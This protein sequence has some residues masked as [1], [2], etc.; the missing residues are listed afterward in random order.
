MNWILVATQFLGYVGAFWLIWKFLDHA[1]HTWK[2][3]VKTGCSECDIR[4]RKLRKANQ[5][6]ED[7]SRRNASL[8]Q[9][10]DNCKGTVKRQTDPDTHKCDYRLI[11]Q[12]NVASEKNLEGI[13]GVGPKKAKLI[14]QRRPFKDMQEVREILPDWLIQEARKWSTFFGKNNRPLV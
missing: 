14:V 9:E 10:L 8:V 2:G 7:L 1:Y 5:L 6:N 11:H 3:D 13:Y 12:L 4:E